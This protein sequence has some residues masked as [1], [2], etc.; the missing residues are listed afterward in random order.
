MSSLPTT[1]PG[2]LSGH[3]FRVATETNL[4]QSYG[5]AIS[6]HVEHVERARLWYLLYICDHHGSIAYG[7]PPVFQEDIAITYHETF[8]QVP[9]TTQ[10]DWRLQS[11]VAIFRILGRMF[12]RFGADSDKA[13]SEADITALHIFNNEFDNWRVK[14]EP[15]LGKIRCCFQLAIVQWH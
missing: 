13:L 9:G 11:Q 2:R 1:E 8:L 7:R 15:H 12:Q 10:A 14:W 5:K 3:A 4:H 6:G